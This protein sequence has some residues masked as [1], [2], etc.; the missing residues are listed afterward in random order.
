MAGAAAIGAGG[1]LIGGGLQYVYSKKLQRISH[2]FQERMS[3]TAYQRS[4]NDLTKAGLNPILALGGR[5]AS[6]PPG[7]ATGVS[8]SDIVG[9]AKGA[10]RLKG[11]LAL[12]KAQEFKTMQEGILADQLG[13]SSAVQRR[14]NQV[15]IKL[16]EALLPAA[17]A[18]AAVG[19]TSMGEFIEKMNKITRGLAGPLNLSVRG[20]R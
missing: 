1:S 7:G 14:R 4:V 5:G 13:A 20:G 10:A 18:R 6:T 16:D 3:N 8:Q 15:G 12:M 17:T 11:E 19:R 9:S 2:R